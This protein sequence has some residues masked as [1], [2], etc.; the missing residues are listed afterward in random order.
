M[1]AP[2]G[3]GSSI[4]ESAI[5]YVYRK[6]KLSLM[7]CYPEDGV[8]GETSESC[9]P[10]PHGVLIGRKGAH[11]L[12]PYERVVAFRWR[13][14]DV[15]QLIDNHAE[16]NPLARSHNIKDRTRGRPP[17][18]VVTAISTNRMLAARLV[19]RR[20]RHVAHVLVPAGDGV[21]GHDLV[22]F[23]GGEIVL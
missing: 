2:G 6:P 7:V 9:Q 13:D 1:F 16:I 4:L 5:R 8:W 3:A 14:E 12:V 11:H 20:L 17:A 18:R 15:L 19:A 21:A 10:G 22:R 23:P